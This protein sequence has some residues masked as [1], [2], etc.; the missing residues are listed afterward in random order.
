MSSIN[1]KWPETPSVISKWH[2]LTDWQNS[3]E[4][5]SRF[6]ILKTKLKKFTVIYVK[7]RQKPRS[8]RPKSSKNIVTKEKERRKGKSEEKERGRRKKIS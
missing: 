6:L 7:K 2:T 1:A 3:L 4:T 8:L 5:S